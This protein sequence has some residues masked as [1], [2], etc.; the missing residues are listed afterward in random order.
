M[1]FLLIVFIWQF[2]ILTGYFRVHESEKS[3]LGKGFW[4]TLSISLCQKH[5]RKKKNPTKNKRNKLHQ[6]AFLQPK[7]QLKKKMEMLW[8]ASPASNYRLTTWWIPS[9]LCQLFSFG[10]VAAFVAIK[11]N[12]LL[13]MI[14]L[15][16]YHSLLLVFA[17]GLHSALQHTIICNF[18]PRAQLRFP[19]LLSILPRQW[20]TDT[21]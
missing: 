6:L 2:T 15:V 3:E 8:S 16:Q 11:S 21:L 12:F 1:T 7:M 4:V 9:F 10:F 13:T 18:G 20:Q 19:V 14:I 17:S 5:C